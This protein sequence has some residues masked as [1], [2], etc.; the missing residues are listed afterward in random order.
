MRIMV[1]LSIMLNYSMII[2]HSS[3][4]NFHNRMWWMYCWMNGNSPKVTDC[5]RLITMVTVVAEACVASPWYVGGWRICWSFN[6]VLNTLKPT[7]TY[8]IDIIEV[9]FLDLKCSIK[10]VWIID[11]IFMD[12]RFGWQFKYILDF[13]W[14]DQYSR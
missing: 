4:S 10:W 1:N 6:S 9:L 7:E 14:A 12:S 2:I 3:Y 11:I 5:S 13:V 8:K